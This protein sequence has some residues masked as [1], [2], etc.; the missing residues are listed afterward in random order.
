MRRPPTNAGGGGALFPV[1]AL[2]A[3]AT[4]AEPPP[5]RAQDTVRF[6]TYN[7]SLNRATQGQLVSDLSTPA[8]AQARQVAEILQ[9]VRPD[10]V[11]LN[12]F[13]YDSGG[14]AARLFQENYL[15]VGQRGQAPL[16]YPYRFT[17][18]VNTGVPSGQDYNHDGST[19]G[20]E[21]G[22]GYGA[23]PGQYGMV[24]YSKHP[25]DTRG[26]RRL[27]LWLWKDLPG[28][29]LPTV[30]ATGAP[31]YTAA[32]LATF[33]LSSKSHWD[34][35]VRVAETTTVHFVVA[36]P[37]PP[38][39]DGA[40]DRNGRRNHDEIRLLADYVDPARSGYLRDDTGRAGGL[41]AGDRFVIAGDLNADPLDGDSVSNAAV[42]LV[43]HPLINATVIPAS[44]GAVEQNSKAA[45]R[46]NP[47]YDT[48]AFSGSVG[49][50][51]VDYVLP[52]RTLT[53]LAGGV[54]WPKRLDD[55]YDLIAASDHR[56]VWMDVS[57][58][59]SSNGTVVVVE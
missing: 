1:C 18:P 30:P 54:F 29:L 31:Y 41:K 11:L 36:H 12:E 4:L 19:T 33:R 3:A 10:V 26:V 42:Q 27:R 2:L 23:F 7:A 50:L 24:V 28:A 39:F 44:A 8:N 52:S 35:P 25:L 49:H 57:L 17:D 15:A 55:G 46:G 40:E 37:T 22:Y 45:Q 20:P 43:S 51:R 6:A 5:G 56:L 34:L 14:H 47:A 38:A 58:K 59:P 21:D 16:V 9:R 48:A 53:P 32:E 13:D